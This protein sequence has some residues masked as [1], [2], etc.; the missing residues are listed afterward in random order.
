MG[1][2]AN[3]ITTAVKDDPG[4]TSVL[5]FILQTWTSMMTQMSFYKSDKIQL[6]ASE[7]F[8]DVYH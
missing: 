8:T 3:V 5:L 1:A 7:P 2:Q 6:S 4:A